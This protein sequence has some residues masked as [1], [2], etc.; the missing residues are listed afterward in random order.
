M[1]PGATGAITGALVGATD[2]AT[3]YPMLTMA[4]R[5]EAGVSMDLTINI[6][7]LSLIRV[8]FPSP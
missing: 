3:L 1:T 2:L 7:S 5:R 4:T 6:A 8:P